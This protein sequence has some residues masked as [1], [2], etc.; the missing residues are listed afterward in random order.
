MR[1]FYELP[2][3]MQ[4]RLRCLHHVTSVSTAI[5]I[6]ETKHIFSKD[7]GF[8]ANFSINQN[9][10]DVLDEP[11]EV[12]LIFRYSGQALLVPMDFD[13]RKYQKNVLYIYIESGLYS[14]NLGN[15]K[16]W[17][18]RWPT[19]STQGMRCIGF[20]LFKGYFQDLRL[21]YLNQL[22]VKQLIR[23]LGA[24]VELLVPAYEYIDSYQM[25]KSKINI[26][27]ISRFKQQ[28]IGKNPM[29]NLPYNT[30]PDMLEYE[31]IMNDDFNF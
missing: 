29:P 9:C 16:A 14:K 17:A 3:N 23:S 25:S 30:S 22:L 7:I 11:E 19:E 5:Q 12:S 18:A 24:G 8:D 26:G 4:N 15:L 27:A 21:N 13:I 20:R 28:L 1:N 31:R 10:K 6:L 2:Q